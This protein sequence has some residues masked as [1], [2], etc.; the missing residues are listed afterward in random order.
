MPPCASYR[1]ALWHWEAPHPD[2]KLGEEWGEVVSSYATDDSDRLLVL[3][4]LAPPSRIDELA[5]A[6]RRRSC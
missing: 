2:W 5:P 4:P 1:Q 6:A 3:D